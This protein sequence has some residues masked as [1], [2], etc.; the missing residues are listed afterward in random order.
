MT[1][2][3]S[4]RNKIFNKSNFSNWIIGGII[5]LIIAKVA[6]PISEF[7]F[8]I[9]LKIGGN[10]VTDISNSTYRE[11]SNGFSEQ[12]SSTVLYFVF[13]IFLGLLEYIYINYVQNYKTHKRELNE[14][15]T[16]NNNS[17]IYLEPNNDITFDDSEGQDLETLKKQVKKKIRSTNFIF[18]D[19]TFLSLVLL[20]AITFFY[21][22][23]IFIRNKTVALT[24]NIEIVSPY[25]TDVEYKQLKSNF[26]SIETQSDYNVLVEK[27]EIIS[28]KYSLKLK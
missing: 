19:V 3:S 15:L 16:S 24:N 23:S 13:L 4:Q 5:A 21:G 7:I 22:Q 6:D 8:S 2:S 11:I 20:L 10:F 26:H 1:N 28:D 14:L 27:L 17:I 25:I 18:L 12:S 9:L